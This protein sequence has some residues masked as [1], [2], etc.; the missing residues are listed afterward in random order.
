MW[1]INDCC[2][3]VVFGC[4]VNKL[5]IDMVV[6]VRRRMEYKFFGVNINGKYW[7]EDF[8]MLF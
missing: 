6:C 3:I 1:N 8:L 2:V 7:V 5:W 4:E